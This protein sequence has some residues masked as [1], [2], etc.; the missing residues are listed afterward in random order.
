M[1]TAH[2]H[3]RITLSWCPSHSNIQGNDRADTLAKEATN[4]ARNSPIGIT[5][6][7]ALRRSKV[8]AT[9]AWRCEW[10][11]SAQT[12]RFA[13]ANRFPPSLKPTHHFIQLKNDRELFGRVLQC[14]TGHGYT[15]EF[16][17][18]FNLEARY[19]CPCGEH[20]ETREHILRD[21]PRFNLFRHHL[22]KASPQI[23]LPTILGTKAGILA[24]IEFLKASKAFSRPGLH[25]TQPHFDQEPTPPPD[26][27]LHPDPDD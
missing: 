16:R 21:C 11:K 3:I 2:P 13:I 6:T 12:G 18:S 7:N 15:G 10:R 8:H 23:S 20:L 4:L 25:P 17:Q 5:R 26:E 22:E 27:N 1:L 14:R 9:K 24:L 19:S